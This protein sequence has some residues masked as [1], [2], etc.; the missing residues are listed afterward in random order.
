[1]L[2]DVVIPALDEEEALPHVLA[3]IPSGLVRRVVV[4]DNGSRDRTAS[5]AREAGAEVVSEPRRGYGAACLK[6]L[7]HL[8]AD[9]PDVVVFLDGDHS[10]H[11]EEL[12]SLLAPISAGHADF[13]VGSRALG[14]SERGSLTPQQ[15]VGNA[16]ACVALRLV[17]GARYTDLGPFRAIRWDALEELGMVDRDYGWTVEMQIK[18]ARRRVPHAEVPV[19]YRRRIGVSK[20]SGT[21]RG[22]LGAS[23]KI[24]WVLAR[25]AR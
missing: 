7:A 23:R 9:P 13:V 22:T 19:S 16:I 12:P 4:A 8:R 17:Y 24:L 18:A 6:A 15:R 3:A 1:M 2:V 10:D 5:R 14:V 21:L 20:V 11:P 25:H